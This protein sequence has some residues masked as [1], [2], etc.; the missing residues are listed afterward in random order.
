[1]RIHYHR[2]PDRLTVFEQLLV[3]EDAHV[4]IT[5]SE[6]AKIPHD[7]VVNGAVVLEV[8]APVVW[9]TFPGASYDIGR[10]HLRD[11]RFTGLYT[12]LITPVQCQSRLEWYMTDLYLD[13]WLAADG[14]A[15]ALLD[16]DELE[17]AFAAGWIDHDRAEGVRTEA[18]RLIRAW[19]RESWPPAITN[20]WTLEY[21][22]A[23]KRKSGT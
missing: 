4:L 17:E 6:Q 15:P 13:L 19:E 12:N 21:T 18:Y 5:F 23:A 8:G 11:G 2:L 20:E 3:H 10:F 14:S 9:F 7:V 22:L 16:E 1:M